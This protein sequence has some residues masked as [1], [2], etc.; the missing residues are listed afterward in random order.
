MQRNNTKPAGYFLKQFITRSTL[1]ESAIEIKRDSQRKRGQPFARLNVDQASAYAPYVFERR[2]VLRSK[3]RYCTLAFPLNATLL[4][5]VHSS[6]LP[7]SIPPLPPRKKARQSDDGANGHAAPRGGDSTSIEENIVRECANAVEC[8][9][10]EAADKL[11]EVW[12]C[13]EKGLTIVFVGSHSQSDVADSSVRCYIQ[14][15]LLPFLLIIDQDVLIGS[16]TFSWPIVCRVSARGIPPIGRLSS[17]PTRP[18]RGVRQHVPAMRARHLVH[19]Q[20]NPY[21]TPS[22]SRGRGL[23]GLSIGVEHSS[24][25]ATRVSIHQ[26]Q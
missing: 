16:L 8:G 24:T 4:D 11:L 20:R 26:P 17:H 1:L 13:M 21:H 2:P 6:D 7:P 9:G 22:C 15:Q 18:S 25:T 3:T 12:K 10:V 14:S 5:V 23:G 19:R